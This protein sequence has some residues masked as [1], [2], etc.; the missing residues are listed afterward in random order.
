MLG[1]NIVAGARGDREIDAVNRSLAIHDEQ[2]E[3]LANH[4]AADLMAAAA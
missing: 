3:D 1:T 4:R 2:V